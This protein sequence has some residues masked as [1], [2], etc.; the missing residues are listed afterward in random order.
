MGHSVGAIVFALTLTMSCAMALPVR[1]S[2]DALPCLTNENCHH[3]QCIRTGVNGTVPVV[4]QCKCDDNYSTKD[5]NDPS[6]FCNTKVST[7]PS[8]WDYVK[9]A[10]WIVLAILVCLGGGATLPVM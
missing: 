7:G 2:A 9:L 10:I 8:T 3:G 4:G 5:V 6:S 1:R